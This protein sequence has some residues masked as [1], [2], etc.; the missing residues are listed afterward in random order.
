MSSF[1]GVSGTGSLPCN[2]VMRCK[3]RPLGIFDALIGCKASAV[4][5]FANRRAVRG[6]GAG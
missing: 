1:L 2:R 3:L 6:T 5:L 4:P